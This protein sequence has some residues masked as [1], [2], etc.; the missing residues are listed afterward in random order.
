MPSAKLLLKAMILAERKLQRNEN[1]LRLLQRI[2][3]LEEMANA[4]S[5][6]KNP[7]QLQRIRERLKEMKEQLDVS[8]H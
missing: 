5:L 8:S 2:E 7:P 4:A 6:K 3:H 1:G